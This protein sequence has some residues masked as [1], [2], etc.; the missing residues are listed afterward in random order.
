MSHIVCHGMTIVMTQRV[1]YSISGVSKFKKA[2]ISL[3]NE[4]LYMYVAVGLIIMF[5]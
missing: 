5:C 2:Q 1:W 4:L 3:K